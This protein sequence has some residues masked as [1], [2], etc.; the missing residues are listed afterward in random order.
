MYTLHYSP[1]N[2]SFVVRMVLAELD[3]PHKALLI[4][5]EAGALDS[6][7]YRAV[8]PLGKI[9]AF[10]TPDG[11]M[12]E[13]A[14]ILLYL[15]DKH[16]ALAPAPDHPDRAGFLAW[17][18]FTSTNIHPTLLN[19][20]YPDRAAGPD[21]ATQTQAHARTHMKMLLTTLDAML[22]REAPAWCSTEPS[23]LGYYLGMLMHWLGGNPADH[24]AYFPTSDYPALQACLAALETRPAAQTIAVAEGLGALPF[25]K[26]Y[27]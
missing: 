26:P 6:P 5:R 24:P 14:A 9:P 3:L 4:D 2:A 7:A 22:S 25:T 15:A 16:H 12:F 20:F 11:P 10:E 19:L 17:L 18:F 1:D 27:Q 21:C 8:H 23:I 13:T